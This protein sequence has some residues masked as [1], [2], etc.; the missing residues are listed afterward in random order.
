MLV[1]VD[2]TLFVKNDVKRQIRLEIFA[3]DLRKILIGPTCC[4]ILAMQPYPT[5]EKKKKKKLTGY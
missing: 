1:S 3:R 5:A 4:K 2:F